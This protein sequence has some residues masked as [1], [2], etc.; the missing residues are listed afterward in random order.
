MKHIRDLRELADI[1][2]KPL[3]LYKKLWWSSEASDDWKKSNIAPIFQ[4]GRKDDHRNYWPFF[5]SAMLGK[6]LLEA[7]VSHMD[8]MEVIWENQYSFTKAGPA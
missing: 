2:A 6:I 4:K 8:E 5:F 1:V 7:M 3:L